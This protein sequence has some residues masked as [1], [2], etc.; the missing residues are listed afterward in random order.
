MR[1]LNLF[2]V[3]ILL[4][5]AVVRSPTQTQPERRQ[6]PLPTP[7]PTPVKPPPPT[8]PKEGLLSKLL[9]IT[10]ISATPSAM[11][12]GGQDAPGSIW[13]ANSEAGQRRRLTSGG[14]YKSPIFLDNQTVLALRGE[15]LIEIQIESG[16]AKTLFALPGIQKL[17]GVHADQQGQVLFLGAGADNHV[18]VGLLSLDSQR[19]TALPYNLDSMS[20]ARTVTYLQG[21]S[22]S[23]NQGRTVLYSE[24]ETKEGSMAVWRDVFLKQ[25]GANPINVS[26]CDRE[27]CIQPSLS[28]NGKLVVFIR[29]SA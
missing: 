25:A 3:L 7:T 11:K 22:R 27:D 21:W 26:R 28:P 1:I 10:G 4:T 19:V 12:G 16:T 18:L 17:V 29:A 23:Y 9:R 5:G 14:D 20:D 15:H 24:K 2:A 6:N 13:I 8:P